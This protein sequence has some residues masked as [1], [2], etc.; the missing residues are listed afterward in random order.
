MHEL[1]TPLA[2]VRSH[3]ESEINNQE[4]SS[5]IRKK[6]ALDV[7]ALARLNNLVNEMS[8]LLYP[9]RICKI[10]LFTKESLL[11]L[12]VDLIEFIEPL[13]QMKEQKISLVAKENIFHL[14]DKEKFQQLLL[15]L[16]SNA[17]KYTPEKGEIFIKLTQG[18]GEIKIS[19]KDTGIGMSKKEKE[20][21]FSPFYRVDKNSMGGLGLGLAIAHAI[22]LQ[23][24][25]KI[26]V[27]SR[28][29]KGS[30]FSLLIPKENKNAKKHIDS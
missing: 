5:E 27:K 24:N 15:N 29:N 11:S 23:H 9:K 12:L 10:E 8:F 2:I 26:K 13:A 30:T 3:L 21:I 4:L 1:K 6:L 18:H 22:S 7:E 20:N 25:I 16:V 28:V 14:I 19:I 17:I